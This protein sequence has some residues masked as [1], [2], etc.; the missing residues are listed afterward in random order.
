M[1]ASASASYRLVEGSVEPELKRRR[2]LDAGG[3]VEDEATARQK[4]RNAEVY[5]SEGDE[6][7]GFDPENVRDRKHK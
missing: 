1:S 7:V 2:L 5:T 6:I 4:M 3:P